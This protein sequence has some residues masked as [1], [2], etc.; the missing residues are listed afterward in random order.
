M[1]LQLRLAIDP[2]ATVIR[3]TMDTQLKIQILRMGAGRTSHVQSAKWL[4]V[5]GAGAKPGIA[6]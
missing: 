3:R 5:V 4:H 6:T 2:S 1:H